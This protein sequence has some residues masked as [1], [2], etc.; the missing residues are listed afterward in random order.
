MTDWVNAE[1]LTSSKYALICILLGVDALELI[2]G[3]CEE[4][5]I[6]YCEWG[7]AC[8]NFNM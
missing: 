3:K 2:E 4:A 5:L 1:K 6:V 8:A 7:S